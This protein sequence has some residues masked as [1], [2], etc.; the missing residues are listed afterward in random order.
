MWIAWSVIYAD[1]P[2]GLLSASLGSHVVQKK[3]KST[4]TTSI[5]KEV[6]CGAVACKGIS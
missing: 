2:T 6:W 3:R 5:L 1:R 4:K